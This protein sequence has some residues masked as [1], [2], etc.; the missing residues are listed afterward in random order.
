[1]SITQRDFATALLNPDMPVPK[2]LID[3]Q[4]QPA[5]SRFNVYRNTVVAGLMNAMH[6]AFPVVHKLL[7]DYLFSS[8]TSIYVRK[9]PPKSPVLMFYGDDFPTFLEALD[10]IRHLP[11]LPDIARLELARRLSYHS[12]DVPAIAP[13][14]LAD[15][16][17]DDLLDAKFSFAPAMRILASNYAIL[18]IW[19]MSMVLD[20]PK[21]DEAGQVVLLTRPALDVKMQALDTATHVFLHNLSRKTLGVAFDIALKVDDDFDLSPAIGLLLRHNLITEIN[22]QEA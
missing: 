8:I 7:G 3:P 14:K 4:G 22:L 9:Y 11:Y 16:S 17:P 6:L 18:S 13:Q 19:S 1:M 20:A 12:A 15:L 5:R 10:A 21:L 2:G